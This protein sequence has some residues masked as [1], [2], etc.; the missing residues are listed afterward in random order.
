MFAANGANTIEVQAVKISRRF[1]T[2]SPYLTV[3]FT[4]FTIRRPLSGH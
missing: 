1:T 4:G 3:C 2:I